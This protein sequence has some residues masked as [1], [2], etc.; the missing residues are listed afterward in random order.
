MMIM[1]DVVDEI[2]ILASQYEE[3]IPDGIDFDSSIYNYDFEAKIGKAPRSFWEQ[4]REFVELLDG[5]DIDGF[6]VFGLKNHFGYENNIFHFNQKNSEIAKDAPALTF[7]EY[8]YCILFG[9][10]SLDIYTYDV[11]TKKWESRDR[12][13]Y[14]NLFISCNTLTEFLI[15]LTSEIKG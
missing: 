14:D 4:Y 9:G 5:F 10:S 3:V 8:Q 15:A 11:R 2:K 1:K 12:F 7:D 13:Q 6:Y